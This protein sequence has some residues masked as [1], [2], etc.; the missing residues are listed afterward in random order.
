MRPLCCRRHQEKQKGNQHTQYR[1]QQV[2]TK[3]EFRVNLDNWL[4]TVSAPY[5]GSRM[6]P[7]YFENKKGY[8]L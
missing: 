4:T 6:P 3:A 7:V 2:N 8:V 5:S 1:M